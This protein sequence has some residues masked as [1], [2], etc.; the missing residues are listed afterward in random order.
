MTTDGAYDTTDA[1]DDANFAIRPLS[2]HQ[3]RGTGEA[4]GSL[5]PPSSRVSTN[6]DKER[7]HPAC[8]RAGCPFTSVLSVLLT[9]RHITSSPK[10]SSPT[11]FSPGSYFASVLRKKQD[12]YLGN[13]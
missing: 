1:T 11:D 12:S 13:D 10:L 4:L 9:L 7:S 2:R 3:Q 5:L 8:F 6:L